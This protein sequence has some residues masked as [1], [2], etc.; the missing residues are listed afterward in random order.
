MAP[1]KRSRFFQRHLISK[2]LLSSLG[3]AAGFGSTLGAAWADD[4]GSAASA[5][6]SAVASSDALPEITVTAQK[7]SEKLQDVAA[8]ASVITADDIEN[9]GVQNIQD[10]A[11]L[12]P[13][14]VITDQLR[15]G[16]QNVS[17]RGFTTV[18]GGQSPFAIVIDGVQQPGQEF[19]KQQLVD[20]QQIEVLRGPQGTLYGAGAIAGALNIVTKQPT[21]DFH[22]QA[23]LGYAQGNDATGTL[24]VSGPIIKDQLFYRASVYSRNFD[25]LIT[26]DYDGSKV[27]GVNERSYN[28]QLLYTPNGQLS[29][30]LRAHVTDGSN[31][32]L[33]LVNAGD[34]S[35][36]NYSQNPSEDVHGVDQRLLQSYS[37]KTDYDFGPMTFT[38]IS[39]FN[40]AGQDLLADGD[41]TD[42]VSGVQTWTNDTKSW[43]EELRL[44]SNGHDR[45]R[46]NV[47]AWGQ[48][49][50]VDDRTQ[51]GSIE[52][53]GSYSFPESGDD[54][55]IYRYTSW[56]LFGQADYDLTQK[57]T[58]TLG[59]RY[60]MVD[61]NGTNLVTSEP[62]SHKFHEPQPKVSLSYQFTPQTM[63]Y[64]TY[65]KG[66][67]TGGFN[68]DTPLTTGLRVYN[69]EVSS[70]YEIGV[71][72]E[73]FDR[74]LILN[75]DVFH[76]D[77]DNQQYFYSVVTD[78]GI[79]RVITNIPKTR[80]NGA[81][82]EFNALPLPWLKLNGSVG[83]N[84]TRIE[85]FT[86]SGTSYKGN[87]VPQ[88]Y[89]LT[90]LLGVEASQ[91]LGDRLMVTGRV[92][93]QH[94]GGLYYD[95]DNTANQHVSAKDFLNARVALQ[96]ADDDAWTVAL[97]GRNLTDERTVA[98]VG[99][100]LRSYNEPRQ[101]GV[102]LQI[103]Y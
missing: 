102:E 41:F 28:G 77:F 74:R 69:N 90:T 12:T 46:W 71:K 67:R 97:V 18:Q 34:G 44:T 101:L 33:W 84:H 13:N 80:V 22:A 98:A 100:S 20:I 60:D 93:W 1:N 30:D 37:L 72:N 62:S 88:V 8:S 48:R 51:Y 73:F 55:N 38:S 4:S 15:P 9:A 76:T 36:D 6:T 78:E 64:A 83:Y 7:R 92:D 50:F 26:N 5:D 16:I 42:T 43:S 59:L 95:L 27:D 66:F 40:K 32:A 65:G 57:L 68:P 96:R 47:G 2:V 58:A 61:A 29:M 85:R 53:D 45:L 49:Y 54:F 87:E 3:V 82:L 11:A 89:P 35:I 31:G 23:K 56:A 81:E 39:A 19:L 79:Y 14:L 75:A 91:P 103:R 25:G 86:E 24:T 21:N 10:A 99:G 94:R 17:F 63:G 70:N 52:S